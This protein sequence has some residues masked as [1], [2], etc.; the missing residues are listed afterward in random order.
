M[1]MKTLFAV[2]VTAILFAL[3]SCKTSP[4]DILAKK[5]KPTD[6]SGPMISADMKSKI[7]AGDNSME[8]M[9]DGKYSNIT[10]GK[11]DDKGTYT[12]SEDG[13]TITLNSEKAGAQAISVK[14]LTKDRMVGEMMGTSI[15][16]VPYNK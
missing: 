13:K 7:L 1:K 3:M 14:E 2:F 9:K 11:A 5:W 15:T 4:K 8:F 10:D 6:V 12:L 16:F